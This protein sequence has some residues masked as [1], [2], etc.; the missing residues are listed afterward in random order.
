M[1]ASEPLAEEFVPS[2]ALPD[3]EF[4]V[5]RIWLATNSDVHVLACFSATCISVSVANQIGGHKDLRV[6]T[7]DVQNTPLK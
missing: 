5:D 2:L 7:T 6:Y 4:F 1:E 3:S